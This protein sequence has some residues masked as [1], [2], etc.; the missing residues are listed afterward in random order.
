MGKTKKKPTAKPKMI[1]KNEVEKMIQE[2]LSSFSQEISQSF[3]AQI[4][5]L[6]A[7]QSKQKKLKRIINDKAS[8]SASSAASSSTAAGSR[9]INSNTRVTR[10]GLRT[11][12]KTKITK[13]ITASKKAEINDESEESDKES[14]SSSESQISDIESTE[15]EIDSAESEREDR[16]VRRRASTHS[17]AGERKRKRYYSREKGRCWESD[18]P[19][20][21]IDQEPL[22][23]DPKEMSPVMYLDILKNYF[24]AHQI[25]TNFNKLKVAEFGLKK[26]NYIWVSK[27][28]FRSYSEF[29]EKFIE[30]FWTKVDQTSCKIKLFAENY[31]SKNKDESLIEFSKRQLEQVKRYFPD[32]PFSKVRVKFADQVPTM[33]A[34]A[35]L[36]TRPE[37]EFQLFSMIKEMENNKSI[38]KSLKA[39]KSFDTESSKS[40]NAEE[41][42]VKSENSSDN[43][44]APKRYYRNQQYN[45][46]RK[47][48]TEHSVNAVKTEQTHANNR[49]NF[50]G[51][52]RGGG[53]GRGRGQWTPGGPGRSAPSHTQGGTE[54]THSDNMKETIRNELKSFFEE[55]FASSMK[56]HSKATKPEIGGTPEM[57]KSDTSTEN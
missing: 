8:S 3:A 11:Q 46:S 35:I 39:M 15:G 19:S 41:A 49:F 10:S 27:G 55:N 21:L 33:I 38:C 1:D 43:K 9:G 42:S 12:T 34:T 25:K 47:N 53:R 2:K 4:K 54:N 44:S 16:G 24:K 5:D 18:L 31:K 56:S 14:P 26:F 32:M 45:N 48:Y 40:N 17:H 51:R 29:E 30:A 37:S 50:R 36:N 57:K 13:K 28:N 52:G 23:Y 22:L 20:F 6:L 7:G